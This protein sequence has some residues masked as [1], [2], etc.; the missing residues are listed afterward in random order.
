MLTTEFIIDCIEKKKPISFSKYGDGEYFCASKL[1][2][3]EENCDLD[4]YTDKLSECLKKSFK[5][6]VENGNNSFIGKWSDLKIS[7]FWESLTDK[8]IRWGPYNALT[9]YNKNKNT[10]NIYKSI[11]NASQKKIYVCNELL[12]KSKI[13]LN[14][15]N[16]VLIPFNNWF[17]E[18]FDEV[19]KKIIDLIGI[20]DGNHI[21]ITSCGMSSKVLIC[22]LYKLYPNGIYLDIGSALDTLCTKKNTRVSDFSYEIA[23]DLFKDIIPDNWEDPV[24]EE[25]YIKAKINLGKHINI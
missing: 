17:D 7:N 14:I 22:E 15:D 12:I 6:L 25:I 24:Y 4:K 11:K 18:K 16:I 21:V 5:Y 20:E 1:Y 13:L 2:K 3:S 23:Y 10:V 9:L 8:E 19:L